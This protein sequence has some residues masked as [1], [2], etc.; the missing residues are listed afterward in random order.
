MQFMRRTGVA[1]TEAGNDAKV[2]GLI[3]SPAFALDKRGWVATLVKDPAPDA[4]VPPILPPQDGCPD[5]KRTCAHA[6]VPLRQ[7]SST[8]GFVTF[9]ILVYQKP[10]NWSNG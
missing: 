3:Y 2:A 6:V 4:P 5:I 7:C 1:I 10:R 9:S 8:T